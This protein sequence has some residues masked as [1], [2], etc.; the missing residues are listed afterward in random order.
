MDRFWEI[1]QMLFILAERHLTYMI[2]R[3]LKQ[4][5]IK[6]IGQFYVLTAFLVNTLVS[7]KPCL[8]VFRPRASYQCYFD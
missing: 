3:Y 8:T 1:L 2:I 4:K 6:V 5:S 7:S